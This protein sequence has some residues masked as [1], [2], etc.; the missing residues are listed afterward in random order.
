MMSGRQEAIV[1]REQSLNLCMVLDWNTVALAII[2]PMVTLFI[3]VYSLHLIKKRY[4]LIKRQHQANGLHDA[5]NV[6]NNREHRQSRKKVYQSYSEYEKNKDIKIFDNPQVEEVRADIDVIGM[7][8]KTGNIDKEQF[9]IGYGPLVY[10]CWVCLKDSIENERKI[11][12]FMQYKE[13]FE[14][15]ASQADKYC[16]G[17][18]VDLSKIGYNNR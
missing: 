13:N 17:K 5:F 6:L 4:Y 18:N 9:M 3:G 7:L 8:V 12:N 16:K 10:R 11:R 14:W 2:S 15:L 1:I